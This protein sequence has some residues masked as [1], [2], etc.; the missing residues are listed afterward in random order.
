MILRAVSPVTQQFRTLETSWRSLGA[1]TRVFYKHGKVVPFFSEKCL[2]LYYIIG[3]LLVLAPPAEIFE[4]A[5]VFSG[6][7]CATSSLPTVSEI[8]FIWVLTLDLPR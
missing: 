8:Y 2:S 1:S 3:T 6:C 7:Q 4:T 5:Q